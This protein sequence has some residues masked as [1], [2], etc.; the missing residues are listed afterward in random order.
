MSKFLSDWKKT[1]SW[2]L[3]VLLGLIT[4]GML[5]SFMYRNFINPPVDAML[6][7]DT[8]SFTV[9]Q[10]IQVN[11]LNACGEP[12][13][14]GFTKEYLRSRGYDVVEIGN[15]D[16]KLE[17]SIVIDRVGDHKSARKVAYAMGINDSLIVT[18]I[19]SGMYL[20]SSVILGSDFKGLKP[21]N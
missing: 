17:R 11:V 20:R 21:F 13:I 18:K 15:N 9:E 12:G 1:F 2:S 5:M 8:G 3:T 4:A 7:D 19:D 14:A 6:D 10:V 16:N